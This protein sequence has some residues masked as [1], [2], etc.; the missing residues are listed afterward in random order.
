MLFLELDILQTWEEKVRKDR[1]MICWKSE[2]IFVMEAL[3]YP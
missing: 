1:F 3:S 2:L